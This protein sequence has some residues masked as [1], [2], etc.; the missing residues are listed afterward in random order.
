M[1][2][3]PQRNRLGFTLIEVALASTILV[4]GF[5]GL[6]EALALGS[7]MLDTARKQTVAA[8]II[9]GENEYLHMQN[10]STIQSLTSTSPDYL[11]NY[12]EFHSSNLASLA[13]TSFKFSRTMVNPDPHPYLRQMTL[14]VTWTSITGKSHSRSCSVYVGRNGL[15]V[16]YRKP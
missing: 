7:E 9:D 16:S 2:S 11:S 3:A 13:G 14:T 12:S 8:Q 10:W 4:V 15:N 1:N 6:I 5:V